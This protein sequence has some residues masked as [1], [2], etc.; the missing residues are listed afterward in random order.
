MSILEGHVPRAVV[1]IDGQNLRA[2]E[3]RLDKRFAYDSV[4]QWVQSKG[5]FL[6]SARYYTA[7][8]HGIGEYAA[9]EK[10]LKWLSC[11]DWAVNVVQMRE[12]HGNNGP[13]Y[14]GSVDCAMTV[15]ALEQAEVVDQLYIFSGNADLVPLAEGVRRLGCRVTA[16]SSG[17][18][19]PSFVSQ[20]FRSACDS[21]IEITEEPL[22]RA[23]DSNE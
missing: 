23:K 8:K 21:F 3:R 17:A 22:F 20:E 13:V 7:V 2:L 18:A 19:N 12:Y 16:V 10:L 15:D 6:V 1:L 14:R 9:V 11:H 4:S 5:M